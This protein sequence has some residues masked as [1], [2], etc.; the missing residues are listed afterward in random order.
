MWLRLLSFLFLS[1]LLPVT[2]GRAAVV[3]YTLSGGK[4]AGTLNGVS[5]SGA[6]FTIAANADPTQFVYSTHLVFPTLSQPATSTMTI[7]GFAPF[8]IT[9]VNFGP[10]LSLPGMGNAIGGFAYEFNSFSLAGIATGGPMTNVSGKVKVV[11]SLDAS[12]GTILTT[13]AGDLIF[14]FPSY[15]GTGSFNGD[16]P[17][18][19]VP[20]PTS[21][22]IFG[23]GVSGLAF[24]ARRKPKA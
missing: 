11:G 6:N 20:E 15:S 9:S 16:F 7:D 17:S 10:F 21:L 2:S 23:L 8:E 1:C 13:S 3:T 22:T 12:M 14:A 5:F 4:I 18:L 24:R 19:A